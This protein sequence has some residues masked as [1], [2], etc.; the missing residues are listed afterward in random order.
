MVVLARVKREF[1]QDGG[2]R[3][4]NEMI[5]SSIFVC[6]VE[7][8]GFVCLIKIFRKISYLLRVRTSASV[9]PR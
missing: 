7:T 8:S 4:G 9:F 3:L 1:E 6:S 5:L 2:D